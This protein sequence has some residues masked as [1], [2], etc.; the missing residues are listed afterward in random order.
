MA[1]I[2]VTT[3][4]DWFPVG[5]TVSAYPRAQGPEGPPRTSVAAIASATVDA[6]GALSI[7]NASLL[8]GQLYSLYASVS[9]SHRWLQAAA[10]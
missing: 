9:G 4:S 10:A 1:T 5:A 3:R 7:S 6:A 8:A 2:S